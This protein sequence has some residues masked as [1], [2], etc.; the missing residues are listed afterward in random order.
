MYSRLYR[1]Q[2]DRPLQLIHARREQVALPRAKISDLGRESRMGQGRESRIGHHP[3]GI[4]HQASQ[5]PKLNR[6]EVHCVP[7]L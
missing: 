3:A 7:N 1:G 2:L 4:A 6:H 5:Q